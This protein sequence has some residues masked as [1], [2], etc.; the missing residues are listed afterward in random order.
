MNGGPKKRLRFRALR[1]R[2]L[3]VQKACCGSFLAILRL[4]LSDPSNIWLRK[5]SVLGQSFCSERCPQSVQQEQEM[6]KN[7]NKS[8]LK[9]TNSRLQRGS[10]VVQDRDTSRKKGERQTNRQRKTRKTI[11]IGHEYAQSSAEEGINQ[12]ATIL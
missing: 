10:K 2:M 4:K 12:I 1:G 9:Q 8:D 11:K 5:V 3:A 6:V 7:A